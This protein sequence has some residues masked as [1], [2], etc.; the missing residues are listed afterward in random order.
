MM[1][2]I[3]YN[4]M[5]YIMLSFKIIVTIEVQL[6]CCT[7]LYVTGVQYSGSQFV[8]VYSISSYYKMLGVFPVL[9]NSLYCTAQLISV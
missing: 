2:F 8:T 7:I 6:M 4:I 5:D 3:I 9:Y 1:R